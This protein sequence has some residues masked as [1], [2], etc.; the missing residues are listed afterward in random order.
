MTLANDILKAGAKLATPKKGPQKVFVEPASERKGYTRRK[1]RGSEG[2]LTWKIPLVQVKNIFL[3]NGIGCTV[4]WPWV[5]DGEAVHRTQCIRAHSF[6]KYY[7][8]RIRTRSKSNGLEIS[9]FA[10]D[11]RNKGRK[12]KMARFKE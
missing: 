1:A 7:G 3:A 4:L 8:I 5:G 2:L 12:S 10:A 9:F 6:L 11:K